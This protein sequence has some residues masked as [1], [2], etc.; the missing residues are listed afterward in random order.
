[1]ALG[2]TQPLTEMST[3]KL[4]G[5][6][7]R[8]ARRAQKP[9]RHLW[10]DCLENVG[11]STSQN[12]MGL[13]GLLQGQFYLLQGELYTYYLLVELR[14]FSWRPTNMIC[15]SSENGISAWDCRIG[16]LTR[17]VF[18]SALEPVTMLRDRARSMDYTNTRMLLINT[19]RVCA[20]LMFVWWRN[21]RE[22][23]TSPVVTSYSLVVITCRLSTFL[24]K[25]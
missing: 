13:H 18:R 14:D 11:A 1:M 19:T 22:Q 24:R 9:H 4:S 17:Y 25:Y 6:K 3:R 10:A 16:L 8:P 7:R 23:L 5:G 20:R 12:P 2:S 15:A 21:V